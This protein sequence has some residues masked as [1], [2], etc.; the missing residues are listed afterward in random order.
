MRLRF[1]LLAVV[2]FGTLGVGLYFT[3]TA[4]GMRVGLA[5]TAPLAAW[6]VA[7]ATVSLAAATYLVARQAR[8]EAE[9]VRDEAVEIRGQ[10]QALG[11]QADAVSRQADTAAAQLVAIQRP[12]VYPVRLVY[13]GK[14]WGG[15]V[16]VVGNAG[17]GPAVNTRAFVW[18]PADRAMTRT[19]HVPAGEGGAELS[20]DWAEG[21]WF[22]PSR[23]YLKYLDLGGAEWQT[24]FELHE[25]G[26]AVVIYVGPSEKLGQPQYDAGAWHNTPD[27]IAQWK[28]HPY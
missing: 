26:I 2:A 10:A 12:F 6:A 7:V 13:G 23:G 15:T 3:L 18:W 11:R 20:L 5:K 8:N 25:G 21:D 16:L 9:A 24:H 4:H 28:I 19:A 1:T 14:F 27:D 17:T 22:F